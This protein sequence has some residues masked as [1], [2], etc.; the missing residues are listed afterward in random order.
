MLAIA[1]YKTYINK[2]VITPAIDLEVYE[3]YVRPTKALQDLLA[4]QSVLKEIEAE[5]IK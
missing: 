4:I 2:Q 1:S 5:P 3:E